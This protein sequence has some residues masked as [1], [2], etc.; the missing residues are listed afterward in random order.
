MQGFA[1]ARLAST[2]RAVEEDTLRIHSH[3]RSLGGWLQAPLPQAKRLQGRDGRGSAGI[4]YKQDVST[5]SGS[6]NGH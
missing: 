3:P 1:G 4:S 5:D 6:S 2:N